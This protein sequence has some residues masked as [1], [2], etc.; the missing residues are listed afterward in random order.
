[1]PNPEDMSGKCLTGL[2]CVASI[3]SLAEKALEALDVQCSLRQGRMPTRGGCISPLPTQ[4]E[5][6][7]AEP[8]CRASSE[9]HSV[10]SMASY[11]LQQNEWK[12]IMLC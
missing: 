12:W 11:H 5:R 9:I 10:D 7:R 8:H 2:F 3:K 1:M 6:Q 4:Q